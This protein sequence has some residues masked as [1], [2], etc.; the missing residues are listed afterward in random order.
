MFFS[1]VTDLSKVFGGT[2]TW[3]GGAWR[4]GEGVASHQ[5]VTSCKCNQQ[6]LLQPLRKGKDTASDWGRG[7]AGLQWRAAR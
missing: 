2:R 4:G 5:L 6:V 3:S 7:L 1:L